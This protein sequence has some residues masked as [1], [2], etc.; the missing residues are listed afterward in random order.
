MTTGCSAEYDMTI[1]SNAISEKLTIAEKQTV[2]NK[3]IIDKTNPVDVPYCDNKSC[4][5]RDFY[6]I[7]ETYINNYILELK[8]NYLSKLIIDYEDEIKY[9][10]ILDEKRNDT[11]KDYSIVYN[12]STTIN[13]LE[14][15]LLDTISN[16]YSIT[17]SNNLLYV[18]INGVNS[19]FK[20][21]IDNKTIRIFTPYKETESNADRIY[22]ENDFA[23]HLWEYDKEENVNVKL[24]LDTNKNTVQVKLKTVKIIVIITLILI[25]SILAF[26]L[27]KNKKDNSRI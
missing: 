23:V 2:V 9:G 4:V 5:E 25:I 21:S 11:I 18:N 15:S 12:N 8:D 13:D 24:I 16:D 3:I 1:T 10:K 27:M 14:N 26:Y 6:D 19:L 20:N 7:K 17:K 22:M